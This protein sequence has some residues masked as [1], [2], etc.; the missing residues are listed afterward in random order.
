M[1]NPLRRLLDPGDW[2]AVKPQLD[3]DALSL[4]F[5]HKPDPGEVKLRIIVGLIVI[6]VVAVVV[7]FVEDGFARFVACGF[8]LFGLLNLVY[9]V[10][11][12]GF[13]MSLA[14]TPD[15]VKVRK[16]S[17]F[18]GESWS[19]PL[20]HYRGVMLRESRIR[21]QGVG[22]LE[23]TK[24]YHIIEL[25]HDDPGKTVPLH[26]S[27]GAGPPRA[28]H[29]A[30]ARRLRLAALYPDSSR[31]AVR[32][33][34]DLDRPLSSRG[35]A[36]DPGP[37]PPGVVVERRADETRISIG[38]G[39]L[40]NRL[41]MLFWLA[42]PLIFGFIGYQVEPL[43]G[44]AAAAMAALFVLMMFGL[45]R[46]MSGAEKPLAVCFSSERVWID[47][48]ETSRPAF[49]DAARTAVQQFAGAAIPEARPILESLPLGAVEQIRVDTY[50]SQRDEGGPI[51]YPRLLIEADAG[52]LEFMSSQF[53][54]KKLEWVRDYLEHQWSSPE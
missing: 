21:D 7:Y 1:A 29:E 31:E 40:G 35:P 51:S 33:V 38:A 8:G 32:D 49:V 17:W 48:P 6:S 20:S 34:G 4:S 23:S 18:G 43:F 52:R 27:Q 37:P 30:F 2:L 12:S 46:L 24:I 15:Q 36:T 19:E 5:E 44:L 3:P 9:G 11:Q 25:A 47:R 28:A 14:V 50:V 26:V 22:N 54:R 45:G 10:V 13:E 42:I 39:R 16:K 41:A 53:D